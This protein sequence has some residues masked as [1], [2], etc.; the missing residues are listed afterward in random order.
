[1]TAEA[2]RDAHGATGAN[3]ELAR[4]GALEFG[5]WRFHV[6][7]LE[8]HLLPAIG[9][10]AIALQSRADR[11]EITAILQKIDHLE[12][13]LVIRAERELQRLL[14]GDCAMPVGVRTRIFESR[15]QMEAILFGAE[16]E[17]PRRSKAEGE[18]SQPEAVAHALF[19]GLE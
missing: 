12:T 16:S 19:S 5:G 11:P 9:Q 4:L 17:P 15:L 8:E 6:S 7:S 14:A 1:M 18:A 13:H 10:G 2:L 3:D